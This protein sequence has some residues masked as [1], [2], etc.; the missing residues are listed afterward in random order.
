MGDKEAPPPHLPYSKS[1]ARIIEAA[2]AMK[3]GFRSTAVHGNPRL[4]QA[5]TVLTFCDPRRGGVRVCSD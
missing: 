4:V 3:I 2:L 1:I 5:A